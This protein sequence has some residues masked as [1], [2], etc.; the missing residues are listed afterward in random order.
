MRRL[1]QLIVALG[2]L[3]LG[4]IAFAGGPLEGQEKQATGTPS[5]C[6]ASSWP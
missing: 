6:S 3:A 5:S 2:L 1:T 4:A